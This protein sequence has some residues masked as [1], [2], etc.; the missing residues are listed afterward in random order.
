M[1]CETKLVNKHLTAMHD[2]VRP[3]DS[4]GTR[5]EGSTCLQTG[6]FLA[7]PEPDSEDSSLGARTAAATQGLERPQ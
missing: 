2:A 4:K 1:S 6:S 3:S 5:E 7:C